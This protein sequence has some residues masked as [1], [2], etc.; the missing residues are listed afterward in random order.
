M[1]SQTIRNGK[2]SWIT[3]IAAVGILWNA[4]GIYQFAASFSQSSESLMR[5]GLT[6]M[7]AE[8]Y[9]SLPVWMDVAFGIG[10]FG[11]LMGSVALLLGRQLAVTILGASL[12]AYLVLFAGDAYYGLFAIPSQFVILSFVI[13]ISIALYATATTAKRRGLLY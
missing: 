6:L 3:A 11:G 1:S 10:V 2:A 9:L 13:V 7:Q 12:A 5:S 8:L 4:F